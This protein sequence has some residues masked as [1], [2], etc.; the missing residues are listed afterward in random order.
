MRILFIGAGSIG[1]RH[2][3][4]IQDN[5]KCRIYALR[6]KVDAEEIPGVT[7]IYSW[8]GVEKAGFDAAFICNPTNLH[9]E[10]AIE[11]IEH[12]IKALFIEKPLG[13]TRKRLYELIDLVEEKKVV[14]YIA[15]P[16]RHYKKFMELR[17]E[18]ESFGYHDIDASLHLI[19]HTDIAKWGKEYSK[20][21]DTGGGPVFELSHE[22]DMVE[23]LFGRIHNI[24]QVLYHYEGDNLVGCDLSFK[25][26]GGIV[27]SNLSLFINKKVPIRKAI[28]R[29]G[30]DSEVFDYNIDNTAYVNQIKYFFYNINNQKM[31]NNIIEG[32]RLFYVLNR[33]MHKARPGNYERH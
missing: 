15:Y 29:I 2:I 28:F 30:Q 20:S 27:K 3:G 17:K 16:F 25:H 10:T 11:C 33:I 31:D 13:C 5:Y 6:H 12:G 23:Y 1:K 19:C 9:I 4:I 21:I 26:S 14:T 24:T 8:H 18:I 7:N 32:S 22:I